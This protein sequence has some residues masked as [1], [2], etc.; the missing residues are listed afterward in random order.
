MSAFPQVVVLKGRMI[1]CIFLPQIT[2][3]VPQILIT[4]ILTKGDSQMILYCYN[5]TALVLL[6]TL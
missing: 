3:G 2:K 4:T 6:N 5:K 1:K